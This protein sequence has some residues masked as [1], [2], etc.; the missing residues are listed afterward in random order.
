[1]IEFIKGELAAL[2]AD[3]AVV[4]VG[5]VGFGVYMSGQAL[6]NASPARA[7]P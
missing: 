4:E 7:V 1:M 3:K 5:G 2:E 6:G